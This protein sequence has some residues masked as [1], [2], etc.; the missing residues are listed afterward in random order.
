MRKG[1]ALL[2]LLAALVLIGAVSVAVGVVFAAAVSDV[3]RSQRAIDAHGAIAPVLRQM[4]ADVERA[5]ALSVPPADPAGRP[6]PLV[7]DLPE[8]RIS[9]ALERDGVVRTVLSS[10]GAPAKGR[11]N[12]WALLGVDLQWRLWQRQGKAY[13]VEVRTAVRVKFDGRVRKKLANSHVLFPRGGPAKG[14]A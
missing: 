8:G 13:A 4:R 7:I 12:A 2:E 6:R 3:P 14:G 5:A 9:Y 10:G 1:I 11:K